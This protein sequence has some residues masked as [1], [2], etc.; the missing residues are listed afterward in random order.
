MDWLLDHSGTL[1]VAAACLLA[2]LEIGEIRKRRKDN[3]DLKEYL[4]TMKRRREATGLKDRQMKGKV[5]DKWR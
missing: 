3:L 5:W 1:F 4:E 2:V